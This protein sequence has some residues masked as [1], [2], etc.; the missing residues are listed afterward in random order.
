MSCYG[1]LIS[2]AGS[3]VHV[4]HYVYL[5][6]HIPLYGSRCLHFDVIVHSMSINICSV[7]QI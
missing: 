3:M 4:G 7:C 2:R 6:S 5:Q 1:G